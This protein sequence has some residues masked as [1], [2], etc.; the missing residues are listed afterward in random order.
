MT[1][2]GQDAGPARALSRASLERDPLDV[3]PDLLGKVLEVDGGMN[4][5]NLPLGLPDLT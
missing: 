2:P 5:A 4:T 1:E 3:A